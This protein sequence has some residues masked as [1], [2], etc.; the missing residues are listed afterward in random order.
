M[1]GDL[2]LGGN[3]WIDGCSEEVDSQLHHCQALPCCVV[4]VVAHQGELKR[5]LQQMSTY[6]F[7]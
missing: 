5:H 2:G 6:H 4:G 7:T 3:K 1:S